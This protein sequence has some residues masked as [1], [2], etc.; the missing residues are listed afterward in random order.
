MVIDIHSHAFPVEYLE[1]ALKV[2]QGFT[3]AYDPEGKPRYLGFGTV[4]PVWSSTEDRIKELDEAGIDIQIL[5]VPIIHMGDQKVGLRLTRIAND[6]IAKICEKQPRRFK[7]MATISLHNVEEA[8]KELER[9]VNDFGAVGINIGSNV[10]GKALNSPDFK[11]FFSNIAER[12]LPVFIHPATPAGVQ[13][14]QEYKLAVLV[15]F[16]CET[17]LAATR[18]V[19][20]GLLEN[21]SH[22][23]L[24]LPHLGGALPY[25]FERID[26]GYRN[27]EECRK[28][29]SL[30]PS[31]Y[32]KKLYYDT[33]MTQVPS[34][35]CALE[36]VGP[37]QILF[38]TDHPISDEFIRKSI[39]NIEALN[40]SD[41]DKKAVYGGNAGRIYN[42]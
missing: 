13:F 4:M 39:E 10:D 27:H 31:T 29:I 17:T 19:L 26:Y 34:L 22:L 32:F 23:K 25:L 1:E 11:T 8:M 3:K 24:I 41:R 14:M 2:S 28:N 7:M 18:L 37:G 38:G 20:S 5:S 12:D 30:P 35:K 36:L 15:G 9:C 42:I 33:A 40:V 16:V 21:Y 6:G